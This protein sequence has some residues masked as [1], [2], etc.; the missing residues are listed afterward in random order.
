MPTTSAILP[1]IIGLAAAK[2]AAIGTV[3]LLGLKA[4][5]LGAKVRR[6]SPYRAIAIFNVFV[7]Y[8]SENKIC[9]KGK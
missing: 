1:T 9:P 5:F 8:V 4:K 3:A 2:T 6:S 7:I